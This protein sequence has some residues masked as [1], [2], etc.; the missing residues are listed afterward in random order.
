MLSFIYS[1]SFLKTSEVKYS[2]QW[3]QSEKHK[4]LPDFTRRNWQLWSPLTL[5]SCIALHLSKLEDSLPVEGREYQFSPTPSAAF[6]SPALLL[7]FLFNI[8]A[9]KSESPEH[10]DK[11]GGSKCAFPLL[12][13]A[14]TLTGLL[15]ALPGCNH[16]W[17]APSL[18]PTL[19]QPPLASWEAE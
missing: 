10:W 18:P 6:S 13:H 15:S 7:H 8:T 16:C 5:V 19:P 4:H 3:P 11:T 1:G 9:A 17:A 2:C 12:Q 14:G